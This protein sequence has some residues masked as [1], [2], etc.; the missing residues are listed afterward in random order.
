MQHS[1]DDIIFL[2]RKAADEYSPRES[3]SQWEKILSKIVVRNKKNRPG[4]A[5]FNWKS[6]RYP[7]SILFISGLLLGWLFFR[8]NNELL[9]NQIPENKKP[10]KIYGRSIPTTATPQKIKVQ[11]AKGSISAGERRLSRPHSIAVQPFAIYADEKSQQI[12]KH[13]QLKSR[14][15][16]S[17]FA[18]D[19]LFETIAKITNRKA[20]TLP[21]RKAEQYEKALYLGV[22]SA[23]D[24]SRVKSSAKTQNGYAVGVIAGYSLSKRFAVET[25]LI[26]N[27]RNY[28]SEGRYFDMEKVRDAMPSDMKIISLYTTSTVME[29]PFKLKY[30]FARLR[31]SAFFVTSG[32]SSYLIT[33]Q[34]NDY[35]TMTN[36][37][38]ERFTSMY[39]K[40][41]FL[42]PAV[43]NM[44]VGYS[45][46]LTSKLDIRA[47]PFLK[48]P[49]KGMGIG[50]LPVTSAGIQLGITRNFY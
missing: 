48:I 13:S 43:V 35:N 39:H 41:E 24:Y 45:H 7:G 38:G 9:N 44:S 33:S 40:N 4:A 12:H 37:V 3:D 6:L 21:G 28:Y 23:I 29:I 42:L 20:N 26:I 17:V 46:S 31:N 10:E 1:E 14:I 36:G 27:K 22:T 34:K 16:S 15:D 19:N 47:E 18:I 5:W 50:N 49:L 11:T 25:G 2:L 30:N 32:M 8:G